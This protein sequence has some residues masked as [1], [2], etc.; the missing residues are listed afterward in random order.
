MSI[1]RRTRG[2][3]ARWP[4]S[5]CRTA[6]W[7]RPSAAAAP[8]RELERRGGGTVTAPGTLSHRRF[9]RE[10]QSASVLNHPNI[11]TIY[12][13]GEQGGRPYLVMELL[14]G[15][16]L[17]RRPLSVTEVITFS[18]QAAA[19]LAGAHAQGVVHRDIK[20]ANIFVSQPARG[21]KQIKI[22]D[23][24]LAKQ[25]GG[26]SQES[27][28]AAT[29]GGQATSPGTGPWP[30]DLTSPGS[31]LGT[32]AYMSPEQAKGEPLD[33][34][35]DLFSLGVVIYEM[36]T[37]SKPFAG[38]STAELFAAL[39]TR[40]PAPLSTVN[41]AMPPQLD[42]IVARLLAKDKEQR[43]QNRGGVVAGPGGGRYPGFPWVQRNGDYG[44]EWNP[45]CGAGRCTSC[46]AGCAGRGKSARPPDAA[47]G[48]RGG[49]C[50][51]AG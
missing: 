21:S 37:G 43:Y 48:G 11:C 44:R 32:A 27:S 42:G 26:D 28:Q 30:A 8:R 36:A 3:A 24:G 46:D 20:P 45:W 51:A 5:W 17:H 23:F 14:R 35:T 18:R 13:I 6:T 12:D 49:H 33:A 25:Q 9:L 39:L 1:G 47:A 29:F 4:S 16:A 38:Q 19:A 2:W 41:P 22:L 50:A 40:D 34:R 7:W 31:T 10:A 15:E